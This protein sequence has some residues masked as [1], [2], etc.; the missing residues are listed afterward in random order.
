MK[1]DLSKSSE[2][3]ANYLLNKAISKLSINHNAIILKKGK[4]IKNFL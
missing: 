4:E 2:Q 3:Y 1:H